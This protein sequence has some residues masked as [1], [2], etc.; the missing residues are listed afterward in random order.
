MLILDLSEVQKVLSRSSLN[1]L[2]DLADIK[3]EQTHFFFF[4]KNL[5]GTYYAVGTVL[6]ACCR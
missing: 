5:V 6:G 3:T 1:C 4:Y 2:L